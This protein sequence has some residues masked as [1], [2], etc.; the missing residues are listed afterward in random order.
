MVR[1]GLVSPEQDHPH[2][3]LVGVDDELQLECL[4]RELRR[5][6]VEHRAFREPDLGHSLTA[7][8]TGPVGPQQRRLFRKHRLLQLQGA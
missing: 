7:V 6:G 4:A 8:A 5:A 3:V 2:L 1:A